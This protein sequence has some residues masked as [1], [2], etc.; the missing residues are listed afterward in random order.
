MN[1]SGL[2]RLP[3]ELDREIARTKLATLSVE[4]DDLTETQK[5]FVHQWTA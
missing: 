2:H 5:E 4:L 1:P 3:A